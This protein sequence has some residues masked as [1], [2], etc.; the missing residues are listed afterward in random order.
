MELGYL[1]SILP[2]LPVY[3]S[4]KKNYV[5]VAFLKKAKY[6]PG[7]G[8]ITEHDKKMKDFKFPTLLEIKPKNQQLQEFSYEPKIEIEKA[9]TPFINEDDPQKING[10]TRALL[11]KHKGDLIYEKY[12]R[13]F[14]KDSPQIGWSLT[15]SFTATMLAIA[16]KNNLL[17]LNETNLFPDWQED[18]RSSI[19][20]ADLLKM[21]SSLE[22]QEDYSDLSSHALQ[23]LYANGNAGKFAHMLP[24]VEDKQPGDVYN[25]STGTSVI[26]QYLLKSKFS[27]LKSYLNFPREYIFAPLNITSAEFTT[28]ETGTY[29]GGSFLYM[30]A[31]DWMKL[32]ELYLNR[33]NWKGKQIFNDSWV[34]FVSTTFTSQIDSSGKPFSYGAHFKTNGDLKSWKDLPEDTFSAVG[35]QGQFIMIIPSKDLIIT[36]LGLTISPIEFDINSLAKEIIG[37]LEI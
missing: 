22:W 29:L 27:D 36:R 2:V 23:M 9:V 34:D 26:L 5:N 33:G 25:Y 18:L 20:V 28:D 16:I 14:T 10:H 7:L 19:S 32:G 37:T 21:R 13:S 35:H 24:L 31:R 8:C 12:F 30:T 1:N 15:K 3:V 6:L 4:E 17:T 11:I